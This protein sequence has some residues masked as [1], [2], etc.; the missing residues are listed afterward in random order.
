M[1]DSL[2]EA[3][4]DILSQLND[5]TALSRKI[6]Q[7]EEELQKEDLEKYI[8]STSGKLIN[9]TLG[10]IDNVQDYISSAPEAKDVTALAELLNA[11]S[12]SIELLNKVYTSIERNKTVKEVKQMDIDSREKINVQDNTAFLLS[13]KEVMKE[14]LRKA[15]SV[16]GDVVD[17]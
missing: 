10:I 11:A 15:D 8:I 6:P 1:E 3:V 12:S 5:T 14:L 16:D 13:R 9:K 7:I 2:D 17:V 4:N